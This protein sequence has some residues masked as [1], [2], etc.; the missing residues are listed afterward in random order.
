M[1]L[2]FVCVVL[3]SQKKYLHK[4]QKLLQPYKKELISQTKEAAQ[5]EVQ[6]HLAQMLDRI[7]LTSNR[8]TIRGSIIRIPTITLLLVKLFAVFSLTTLVH[9][10]LKHPPLQKKYYLSYKMRK[11]LP[12]HPREHELE[13]LSS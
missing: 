13:N 4:N 6:W 1:I 11:N 8:N 3:M 10:S 7:E 2:V 12:L 9:L 5:P